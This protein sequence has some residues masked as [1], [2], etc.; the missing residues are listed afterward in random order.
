MS[1]DQSGA[2][3]KAGDRVTLTGVVVH[4]VDGV[5]GAPCQVRVD[6]PSG[7]DHPVISF[8]NRLLKADRPAPKQPAAPQV[9][10]TATAPSEKT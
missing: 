7:D 3:L 9:A 10:A 2:E 6:A 8:E 5:D 4:A 1:K